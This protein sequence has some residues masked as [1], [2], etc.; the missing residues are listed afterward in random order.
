MQDNQKRKEDG[1]SS[2]IKVNI[3][4][5][6]LAAEHSKDPTAGLYNMPKLYNP[7]YM[8]THIES[9]NLCHILW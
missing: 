8:G 9:F 1:V 4:M 2:G 6:M 3:K 5:P 7:H